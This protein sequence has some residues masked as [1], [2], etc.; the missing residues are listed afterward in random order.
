MIMQ[1]TVRS[2]DSTRSR[3]AIAVRSE[4]RA[5]AWL[6]ATSL[7]LLLALAALS[8]CEGAP[9]SEGAASGYGYVCHA[10]FYQCRL[11]AQYPVGNRCQCPGLGAPSYGRVG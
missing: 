11:P 6:L 3:G 2:V 10:G 7:P 5:G 4:R 8:G 1:R 9:A